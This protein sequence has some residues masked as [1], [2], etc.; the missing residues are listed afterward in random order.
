MQQ[1]ENRFD[2]CPHCGAL[3]EIVSVK[4]GFLGTKIVSSCPNCAMA[5]TEEPI[6]KSRGALNQEERH[7]GNGGEPWEFIKRVNVRAKHVA[8]LLFAAIITA[9]ILRHIIHVY[10][11]L[12]REEIRLASIIALLAIA[13]VSVL[14]RRLRGRPRPDECD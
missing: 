11:G 4:F 3:L 14:F 8:V 7:S 6:G 2:G 5:F 9:G 13:A 10:G 1:I 12:P